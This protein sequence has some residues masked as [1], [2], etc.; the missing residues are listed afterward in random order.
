M[1][2][3]H[4]EIWHGTKALILICSDTRSD[5]DDLLTLTDKWDKQREGDTQ[6]MAK[7]RKLQ[8]KGQYMQEKR[9]L[10]VRGGAWLVIKSASGVNQAIGIVGLWG[11]T[12]CFDHAHHLL[13]V[14][15]LIKNK[16]LQEVTVSSQRC[17]GLSSVTSL[18]M[19][20]RKSMKI[21]NCQI[22][23]HHKNS[24]RRACE[25]QRWGS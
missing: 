22:L 8:R 18:L 12:G 15:C 20:P 1:S 14:L 19:N 9:L 3:M 16:S 17:Q 6:G 23:F 10:L 7:G 24:P 13:Q 21:V 2:Q 4:N 5:E 11:V 25:K